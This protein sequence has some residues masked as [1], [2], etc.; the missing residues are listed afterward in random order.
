MY[1]GQS[2]ARE[3]AAASGR[4]QPELAFVSTNRLETKRF[5]GPV[6]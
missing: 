3:D 2:S 6:A 1:G 5:Y 4:L